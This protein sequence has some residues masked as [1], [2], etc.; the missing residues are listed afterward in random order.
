MAHPVAVEYL[1]RL[2]VT[3]VELLP[4]HQ[5]VQDSTLVERGLRNYWGYNSI[6]YL[7]PHNEYAAA[8]SA[9]SRCRSSSSSS[10]R[11]TRRASK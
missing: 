1:Q 5:F 4:V 2:G 6:G 7:A 10:R 8:A 11:C 9:A 3:A